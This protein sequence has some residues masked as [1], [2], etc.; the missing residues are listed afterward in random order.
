MAGFSNRRT[1]YT[2][3]LAVTFTA[4]LGALEFFAGGAQ[5]WGGRAYIGNDSSSTY[6][7]NASA[8]LFVTVLPYL[9]MAKTIRGGVL[10]AS[11]GAASTASPSGGSR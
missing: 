11:C 10:T 6:D 8:A 5:E 9:V 3:V 7:A 4:T 2:A 1:A